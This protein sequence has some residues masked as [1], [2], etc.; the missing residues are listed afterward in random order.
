MTRRSADAVKIRRDAFPRMF[1][2]REESNHRALKTLGVTSGVKTRG[3][4]ERSRGEEKRRA[5][6]EVVMMHGEPDA[7]RLPIIK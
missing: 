5:K 4:E 6:G 3:G 7:R 2:T 1:K